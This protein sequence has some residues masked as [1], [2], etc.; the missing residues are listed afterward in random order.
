MKLYGL[1][2]G[3]CRRRVCTTL[4]LMMTVVMLTA[5]GMGQQA[6]NDKTGAVQD[7]QGAGASQVISDDYGAGQTIDDI[8]RAASSDGEPAEQ[9]GSE[10]DTPENPQADEIKE[11]FGENCI[12][13]QTFEV[14]L[15]E[16]DGKVWFVPYAPAE[17]GQTPTIQI[18][19]NGGILTDLYPYVPDSLEG[20]PFTSLDAVSF[21]DVNFDG[22]TDIVLIETY[23]DTSFMAL[24]YGFDPDADENE[25][26]FISM[27]SISEAISSKLNPLTVA[28]LRN[29]L[30]GKKNGE[31]ADYREAYRAVL[32]LCELSYG[33]ESDY[34]DL[35]YDLIYVDGD[36]IPELVFGLNGYWVSLYTYHNGQVSML[37]DHWGYGVM[38]N[39]GY[40]YI[41]KGNRLR[42]YNNDYAGAVMYTTYLS[43]TE[44]YSLQTVTE[45]LTNNFDDVNGNGMPDEDEEESIGYYSVSYVGGKEITAEEY[46]AYDAGEYEMIVGDMTLAELTAALAN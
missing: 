38:G 28:Q 11:R 30:G 42:N 37:M 20:K 24:Y 23:G 36:D 26:A 4:L 39:V 25:Q 45:I 29:Q 44:Q 8:E 32:A 40:E 33:T 31:Y 46:A 17:V 35:T 27:P 34:G 3:T 6:E 16:Y 15:S 12:S 5:C 18:V 1:A 2:D 10:A 19:Q 7:T 14:E 41:P 13:E 9:T 22:F 43:M 21:F